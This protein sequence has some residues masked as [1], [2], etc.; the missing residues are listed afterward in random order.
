MKILCPE[1]FGFINV[2]SQT[3]KD[4]LNGPLKVLVVTCPVCEDEVL[5]GNTTLNEVVEREYNIQLQ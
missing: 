5:I 2:H 3:V 4:A 1:H